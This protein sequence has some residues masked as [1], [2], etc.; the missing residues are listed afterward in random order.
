[1]G[2]LKV[3]EMLDKVSKDERSSQ[4]AVHWQTKALTEKVPLLMVETHYSQ[5]DD[6]FI[7][8]YTNECIIKITDVSECSHCSFIFYLLM[9]VHLLWWIETISF[10]KQKAELFS[11][12]EV[13][14]LYIRELY[15]LTPVK[16]S[17][18]LDF[19]Y[20]LQQKWRLQ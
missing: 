20:S 1:M 8:Q 11:Q 10:N 16:I 7:F 14:Y 6:V 4:I 15:K 17:L 2:R 9:T 5:L 12:C 18:L 13:N 19:R 3:S